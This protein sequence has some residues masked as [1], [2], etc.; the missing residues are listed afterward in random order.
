[1]QGFREFS[2]FGN[3]P[4]E[5][6]ALQAPGVFASRAPVL[7]GFRALGLIKG[8]EM[9]SSQV[10]GPFLATLGIRSCRRIAF[11]KKRTRSVEK[12]PD[13]TETASLSLSS[14]RS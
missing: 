1:M 2:A 10:Y 7:L 6:R 13:R 8:R 11:I 14:R 12:L 4:F 3:W 5:L 9:V